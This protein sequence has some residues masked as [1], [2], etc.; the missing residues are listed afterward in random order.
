MKKRKQNTEE[1]KIYVILPLT[2]Q[3]RPDGRRPRQPHSIPMEA[4]RLMAQGEHVV[5]LMRMENIALL[6]MGPITTIN[7]SVRNSK[8]L[9]KVGYELVG[10]T[11]ITEFL[12]KNPEFYGTPH[13]VPTAICTLPLLKSA[14]EEA[15]G[16]L[17]LYRARGE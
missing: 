17:E 3:V 13:L 2:V 12:D 11:R 14:I 8:E 4:G 9:S 6:G 7:L 5:S 16:H 1:K 15:I 10:R